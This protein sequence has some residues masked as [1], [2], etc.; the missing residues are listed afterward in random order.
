MKVRS[1]FPS[2]LFVSLHSVLLVTR[3]FLCIFFHYYRSSANVSLTLACKT[4]NILRVVKHW[5]ILMNQ[6]LLPSADGETID[7]NRPMISGLDFILGHV[8]FYRPTPTHYRQYIC[9]IS[10]GTKAKR[11]R[12]LLKALKSNNMYRNG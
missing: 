11:K 7:S 10:L 5:F 4:Q 6:I 3:S 12:T 8:K 2:Q 9:K 1:S